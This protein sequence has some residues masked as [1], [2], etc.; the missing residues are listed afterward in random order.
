MGKR[1]E[2]LKAEGER[3]SEEEVG[4]A[5]LA[6]LVFRLKPL[7][8]PGGILSIFPGLRGS[9]PPG[10]PQ[11]SLHGEDQMSGFWTETLYITE[12]IVRVVMLFVVVRR[13]NPSSAMA[14]L[15]VIFFEPLLALPFYLLVGENRLPVRRTEAYRRLSARLES[16]REAFLSHPMT[17]VSDFPEAH[18]MTMRL[19]EK[20]TDMPIAGGNATDILTETADVIDRLVA[21]ID[22]AK[23]HV[24]LLYYIYADDETG[25]RVAEALGRAVVRGV[26][27]R[28]LVDAVGSKKMLRGLA[29]RMREWGVDVHEVLPVGIFRRSFARMD[30]RNHRKLAVIDGKLGYT[31]SQNIVN[32]DYGHKDLAWH[33]M[34]VRLRGPIL[35]ELQAVFLNDWVFTTNELLEEEELFPDIERAGETPIQTLPSGPTFATENYQRLIVAAIHRAEKH[36]TITTPYLVPDMALLQ[37]LETAVLRG[38]G[39]TVI[40]PRRCDQV[41]VGAASRSYYNLL[42]SKGVDIFLYEP[43]LLHA[44]TIRIDDS[45]SLIGSSNF[46]IRSFALNFEINMIF[47]GEQFT[48]QLRLEHEDYL[49]DANRLTMAEWQN[50]PKWRKLGEDVARL[51]SPLL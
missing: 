14:W 32:A 5:N 26:K 24:H 2:R 20:L 29:R 36:V 48:S 3:L 15:L 51:F 28:V 47:Y 38:V 25:R 13:Q 49:Q 39:V 46:D 19:T 45:L 21:D 37:A 41:L 4:L 17:F 22:E 40:V 1:N 9:F 33:D 16:T 12:W 30:L 10:L 42:L 11:V 8:F 7:A 18:Q 31:G 23:Y 6:L 27:C 50:R 43:G 34:T 44:K 35:L